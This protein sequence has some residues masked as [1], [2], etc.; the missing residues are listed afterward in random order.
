[1]P[2]NPIPGHDQHEQANPNSGLQNTVHKG[3]EPGSN[4]DSPGVN[5]VDNAGQDRHV[6][7][8]EGHAKDRGASYAGAAEVS[9]TSR[10]ADGGAPVKGN[11]WVRPEGF[12]PPQYGQEANAWYA[13]DRVGLVV[14]GA[15]VA[16]V[17]LAAWAAHRND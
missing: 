6:S 16:L 4:P 10:D 2:H 15:V 11:S 8:N 17:L 1:M 13:D 3:H 5:A 14:A 9:Q 7:H 12:K